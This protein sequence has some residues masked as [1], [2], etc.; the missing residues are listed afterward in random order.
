[1]FHRFRNLGSRKKKKKKLSNITKL[2]GVKLGLELCCY[3]KMHSWKTTISGFG[4][5]L[6]PGKILSHLN[7]DAWY[8]QSSLSLGHIRSKKLSKGD[9][10]VRKLGH[11]EDVMYPISSILLQNPSSFQELC[12]HVVK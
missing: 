5:M 10:K 11:K 8:L 4:A 7:N 3:S 6:W 2:T 9:R 12:P 1:M